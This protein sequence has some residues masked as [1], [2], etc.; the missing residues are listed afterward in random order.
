MKGGCPGR[1]LLAPP[2]KEFDEEYIT[3]LAL[4]GKNKHTKIKSQSRNKKAEGKE[5][6]E[7]KKPDDPSESWRDSGGAAA[8]VT[9]GRSGTRRQCRR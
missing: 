6:A 7:R 8:V 1:A 4:V 9:P 3:M 5:A 2:R